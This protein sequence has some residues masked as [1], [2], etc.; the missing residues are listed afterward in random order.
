MNNNID[1]SFI[2]PVYKTPEDFLTTCVQSLCEQT[3]KNIEIILVDDG[4]CDNC[5]ALCDN[6]ARKDN[7]IRVIHQQNGGVG[8]ARNTGVRAATGLWICFVD[9]DDWA[10]S[11]MIETAL[12][13]IQNDE[14]NTAPDVIFWDYIKEYGKISE[15]INFFGKKE[16]HFTSKDDIKKLHLLS[17][18][19]TSG[20][21]TVWAKLYRRQFLIEHN[22]FSNE[23]LP[24]G[25]DVEY[26]F[27]IF[28]QISHALF[29]PHSTYHYRYDENTATTAFNTCYEEYLL[30]FIKALYDDV[31]NLSNTDE[32]LQEFYT[33]AIHAVLS[34]SVRYTFHKKNPACFSQKKR[35]FLSLL[36]DDVVN[37]AVKQS[38]YKDFSLPRKIALFCLKHR[39]MTGVYL[40]AKYR[41]MQYTVKQ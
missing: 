33:R 6:L 28:A 37:I 5:P 10:E 41:Q 2:L 21:G 35:E 24:R 8:N 27:R 22:L 34:I 9:P 26:N 39:C 12:N 25:Q 4:S 7:R 19:L 11:T 30:R 32:Y 14:N 15:K 29:I 13:A 36:Q 16:I 31:K 3:H 1:V 20:I 23:Y 38:C 18:E 17:L 40:I